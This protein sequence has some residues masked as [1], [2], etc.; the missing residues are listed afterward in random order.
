MSE[1][2]EDRYI[3]SDG[4]DARDILTTLEAVA[5]GREKP[6]K[7]T[8]RQWASAPLAILTYNL[9]AWDVVVTGQA[10]LKDAPDSDKEIVLRTSQNRYP[11]RDLLPGIP[12]RPS[13]LAEP[14]Y[15]F[16]L[17]L[18]NELRT[19]GPQERWRSTEA[20]VDSLRREAK[21]H[22]D[23]RP[24]DVRDAETIAEEFEARAVQLAEHFGE[25]SPSAETL[26]QARKDSFGAMPRRY[27][28][29]VLERILDREERQA[30]PDDRAELEAQREERRQHGW[31]AITGGC[32][33]DP[34]GRSGRGR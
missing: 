32:P 21:Y 8:L 34:P 22:W 17:E 23:G 30:D 29:E 2:N 4:R 9:P 28:G 10:L 15:V 31:Q 5:E 13:L 7:R 26:A 3:L 14:M 16:Q 18:T 25:D 33:D 27:L 11:P 19:G 1:E 20:F 24:Q 6:A 12:N